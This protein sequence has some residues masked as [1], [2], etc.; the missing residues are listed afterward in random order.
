[1]VTGTGTKD[2]PY[3]V[4]ANY[5][6]PNG[7]LNKEQV[8]GLNS[9]IDAYN[10]SGG[11]NGVE[12][13]NAD[14]STSY[15]K[16]NLCAQGVDDVDAARI[17]TAFE[18]TS[19]ETRYYGNTVGTQPNGDGTRG[20]FGSANNRRIDFNVANMNAGVESGMNSIS[21]NKGVAILDLKP[22]M[23]AG[24]LWTKKP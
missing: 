15:V 16:Y 7:S 18:T 21:F 1:M 23:G 17:N 24:R 5:Y 8:G 2:D 11:N 6:Y 19:G 14:G 22:D 10:K 3:V 13:K 12:V 20:E 9:A 4:T